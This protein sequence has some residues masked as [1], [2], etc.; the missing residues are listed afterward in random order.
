MTKKPASRKD[1][2][3]EEIAQIKAESEELRVKFLE[4]QQSLELARRQLA[5]SSRDNE[6]LRRL[7]GWTGGEPSLSG[8]VPLSVLT[9]REREVLALVASGHS[10]KQIAGVL[11][12]SFKTAVSHRS[13]LMEKLEVHETASLVRLA[14]KAGLA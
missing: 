13:R 3:R 10:T 11:G 8:E 7:L 14:I 4:L 6:R 1:A 12:I 2:E 9:R 5:E